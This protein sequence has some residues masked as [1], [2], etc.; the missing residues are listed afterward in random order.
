MKRF[1]APVS[2]ITLF[3]TASLL[4]GCTTMIRL[5]VDWNQH[6]QASYYRDEI[7]S[8]GWVD[9]DW[10]GVPRSVTILY[11]EPMFDGYASL[12]R[13]WPEYGS[14]FG[15]WFRQNMEYAAK[16]LT[17]RAEVECV[18]DSAFVKEQ[19]GVLWYGRKYSAVDTVAVPML[20]RKYWD[21]VNEVAVVI[22]PIVIVAEDYNDSLSAKTVKAL[23]SIVDIRR[24]KVLA[25]GKAEASGYLDRDAR[26]SLS[27]ILL[28]EVVKDTPLE[29]ISMSPLD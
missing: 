10:A 16:T 19:R 29:Q 7:P 25:Y 1:F 9:P 22:S 24:D 26:A 5:A 27:E 28:R 2:F 21:S 20:H 15:R 14:D 8:G 11:A 3:L 6:T 12:K 23:Y 17:A 13:E 4:S 18:D